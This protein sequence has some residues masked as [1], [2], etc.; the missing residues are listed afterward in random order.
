MEKKI[1]NIYMKK[2]V[3]RNNPYLTIILINDKYGKVE[4][5]KL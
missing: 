1:L 3:N 2:C 5:N 4:K